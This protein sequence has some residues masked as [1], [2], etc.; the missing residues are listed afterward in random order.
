MLIIES[1]SAGLHVQYCSVDEMSSS[2]LG[3]HTGSSSEDDV[4][5]GHQAVKNVEHPL[6][7][8]TSPVSRS[9]RRSDGPV[10]LQCKG[11]QPKGQ[12]SQLPDQTD[13]IRQFRHTTTQ[14][15]VANVDVTAAVHT[16]IQ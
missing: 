10:V 13:Q 2:Q 11:R 6:F 1:L 16:G 8:V 3:P 5:Q 9:S 7:T 14:G 12:S 15:E 4:E